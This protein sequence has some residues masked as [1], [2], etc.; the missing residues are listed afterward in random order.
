MQE[1]IF[2]HFEGFAHT[3]TLICDQVTGVAV[4]SP[5]ST[6][7]FC[8]VANGPD[9]A[10]ARDRVCNV[11]LVRGKRG[12]LR[13]HALSVSQDH[14]QRLAGMTPEKI[15]REPIWGFGATRFTLPLPQPLE[16]AAYM[17]RVREADLREL[18]GVP[19]SALE[20]REIEL[21]RAHPKTAQMLPTFTNADATQAPYPI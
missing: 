1:G 21:A 17:R 10:T 16:R 15:L 14:G 6:F 20:Q 2:A 7:V 9:W 12:E 4:R 19:L 5:H 11:E 8:G 13:I 3:A 18:V